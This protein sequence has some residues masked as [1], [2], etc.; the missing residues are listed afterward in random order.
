MCRQS[1]TIGIYTIYRGGKKKY[2][3][4]EVGERARISH[5][6]EFDDF[7][8]CLKKAKVWYEGLLCLI[9]K[10]PCLLSLG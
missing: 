7:Y 10:D 9:E 1:F 2:V 3:A 4:Y 5:E 6:R 8:E